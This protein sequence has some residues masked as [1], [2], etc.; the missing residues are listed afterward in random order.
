MTNMLI[1]LK[2]NPN[3]ISLGSYYFDSS[4]AGVMAY[5]GKIVH[6][7]QVWSVS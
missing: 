2:K 7:E 1:Y 5:R 4:R 3:P 6:V